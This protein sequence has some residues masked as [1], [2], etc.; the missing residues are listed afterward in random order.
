MKDLYSDAEEDIPPNTPEPRGES[1]Q[2]NV[3][4]DV[5]HTGDKITRKSQTGIIILYELDVNH[6]SFKE[7]EYRRDV[8][9]RFGIYC[10][11]YSS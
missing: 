10:P 3:F 7:T 5:H 8:N 4:V 2:I 1:V 9:L 11:A 6:F